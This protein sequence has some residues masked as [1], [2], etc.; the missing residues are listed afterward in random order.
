MAQEVAGVEGE[1]DGGHHQGRVGVLSKTIDEGAD[2]ELNIIISLVRIK[3]T[4]HH[5]CLT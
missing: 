5:Y 2:S 3:N 1:E 4:N